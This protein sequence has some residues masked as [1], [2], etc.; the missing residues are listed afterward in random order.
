MQP[1]RRDWK[2]SPQLQS[3][4]LVVSLAIQWSHPRRYS[5]YR[6]AQFSIERQTPETARQADAKPNLEIK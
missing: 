2:G 4:E 1:G 3:W 5:T 6:I